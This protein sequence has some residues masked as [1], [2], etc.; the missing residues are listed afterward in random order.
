MMKKLVK[1]IGAASLFVSASALAHPGHQHHAL[2]SS[3]HAITDTLLV[4]GLVVAAV[5]IIGALIRR[6][7]S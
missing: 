6:N 5:T 4:L 7:E 1:S 3:S 2:Q